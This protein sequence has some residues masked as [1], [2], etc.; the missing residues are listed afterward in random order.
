MSGFYI[1][2]VI[3]ARH[4]EEFPRPGIGKERVFTVHRG[5]LAAVVSAWKLDDVPV[6]PQNVAAHH[7]VL[8]AALERYTVL[9][10]RFGTVA[11]SVEDL[12]DQLLDRN[13]P[14][15]SNLLQDLQGKVEM[16]VHAFWDE[17]SVVR[18]ILE[19]RAD[20]RELRDRLAAK[21]GDVA[22]EEKIRL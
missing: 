10:V 19:E 21:G 22:R 15:L 20:I 3:R 1:Y 8:E 13:A 5:S 12:Q 4:A 11:P 2:G 16:G 9:P 17:A 14:Q 18:Q 7:H 6:T